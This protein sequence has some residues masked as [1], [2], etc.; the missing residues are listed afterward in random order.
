M[1]KTVARIYVV[2]SLR[3]LDSLAVG[4][5]SWW[6]V[7]HRA[8][9]GELGVIYIKGKGVALLFRYVGLAERQEFLC[10]DHGLATG[11]VEILARIDR[12]I[13]AKAMREHPVLSKL[14]ALARSFQRRSFHLEEPFLSLITGM[15]GWVPEAPAL[16][17]DTTT[18]AKE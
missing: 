16:S 3:H 5:R 7:E 13:H 4:S 18:N 8:T 1:K 17:A 6:C 11:N 14:P 12:P 2:G 9:P 15:L 10:K